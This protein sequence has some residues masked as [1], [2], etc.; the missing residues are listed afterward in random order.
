MA[1]NVG[2][3]FYRIRADVTGL[4]NAGRSVQAFAKKAEAAARSLKK[5]EAS[6]AS[7]SK[8]ASAMS[9]KVAGATARMS[10][11]VTSATRASAKSFDRMSNALL[12]QRKALAAAEI[13]FDSFLQKALD[14]ELPEGNINRL[15]DAFK[16]YSKTLR[17]GALTSDEFVNAQIRFNRAFAD[18]NLALQAHKK[19]QADVINQTRALV[20]ARNRIADL[21]LRIQRTGFARPREETLILRA[22]KVMDDYEEALKRANGSTVA[23]AQATSKFREQIGM[24]Q[25][26]VRFF[27][28]QMRKTKNLFGSFIQGIKSVGTAFAAFLIFEALQRV[29]IDFFEAFDR[30]TEIEAKLKLVVSS[31]EEFNQTF[32]ELADIAVR[33]RADLDSVVT[34]YG[35]LAVAMKN[36]GKSSEEVLLVTES[37]AAALVAGGASAQ[38]ASAVMRQL[39]QA[40]SKGKLDGDELRS[41]LEASTPIAVALAE[42]VR[43]MTGAMELSTGA[44]RDLAE[45]GKIT[46]EVFSRALIRVKDRMVDMANVT[47]MTVAQAVQVLDVRFLQM[48]RTMKN[49]TNVGGALADVVLL[50]SDNLRELFV[51]ISALIGLGLAALF[52]RLGAAVSGAV[53]S[54]RML[55]AEVLSLAKQGKKLAA[56]ASSLAVFTRL[57]R[58]LGLVIGA[59]AGALVVF[60]DK[61]VTIGDQQVRIGLLLQAAWMKIKEGVQ[62]VIDKL[63][64]WASVGMRAGGVV[65]GVFVGLARKIESTLTEIIGAV[66]EFF[67]A[68]ELFKKFLQLR[69]DAGQTFKGFFQNFMKDAES[70]FDELF[71]TLVE[72]AREIERGQKEVNDALLMQEFGQAIVATGFV[73]LPKELKQQV[74]SFI[75]N[76]R[77]LVDK[78][79][80]ERRKADILLTRAFVEPIKI[81]GGL[82]VDKGFMKNLIIDPRDLRLAE[83]AFNQIEQILRQAGLTF[84]QLGNLSEEAEGKVARFLSLQ[85]GGD[86]VTDDLQ[87]ALALTVKQLVELQKQGQGQINLLVQFSELPRKIQETNAALAQTKVRLAFNTQAVSDW[88]AVTELLRAAGISTIEELN[89]VLGTSFDSIQEAKEAWIEWSEELRRQQRFIATIDRIRTS[90]NRMIEDVLIG[91]QSVEDAWKNVEEAILRAL[92]QQAVIEPAVGGITNFLSQFVAELGKG[93]GGAAGAGAGA[94]QPANRQTGGTVKAGQIVRVGE[95]GTELF[96]PAVN[97]RI[98]PATAVQGMGDVSIQIIDQR[99]AG[100]PPVE[101]GESIVNGK[102]QI[103]VL[104]KQEVSNLLETG[105]LDNSML[106]NFGIRRRR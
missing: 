99:G 18:A 51:A 15:T 22:Q 13:R 55:V 56:L 31:Q 92:V 9:G 50:L 24:V 96:V 43:D 40:M 71:K 49:V 100:A 81:G 45:Q 19:M 5:L 89:T 87:E 3:V 25:R 94:G 93:L 8:S 60:N 34:L 38:E 63:K 20:D 104:I 106:R 101:V 32:G 1:L 102:K 37:V 2:D 97:G 4:A 28:D 57:F 35:R 80:A 44:V 29:I 26:Q 76:Y 90:F 42:E 54:F 59:A 14:A 78:A 67:G 68:E 95:S 23:M 61:M 64:E 62:S 98:L 79:L 39:S 58:L 36:A 105:Q 73:D 91:A 47:E 12:R 65:L 75:R 11:K 70:I 46:M 6:F 21:Q 103:S 30:V 33:T 83:N 52:V 88:V 82:E 86:F 10:A 85:V 41:V 69:D 7:I 84:E 27:E 74:L 72:G 48:V 77:V 17:S 16:E 66:F 53:F